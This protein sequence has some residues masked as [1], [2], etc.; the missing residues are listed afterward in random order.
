M[1]FDGAVNYA[2]RR[3]EGELSPKLTYHSFAHTKDEVVVA[4]ERLAKMEGVLGTDKALL[5]TAAYFHDLG[6]IY[7]RKEHE[8]KSA[9]IALDVLPGF[10]YTEIQVGIIEGIILA[11]RLPQCPKT[12]LE[13]IMA[14]GD[15]DGLGQGNFFDRGLDLRKELASFGI[16]S[17]D[18]DWYL[19][20][21]DLL[22]R[23]RYFTKSARRLRN[24]GKQDNLRKLRALIE[25]SKRLNEPN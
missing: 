23:H 14:D 11:T 13:Q 12:H 6:F 5:L 7:Q 17:S 18:Q 21:L 8:R 9:D 19:Q 20:E 24:R 3:L 16:I 4:V 2:L 22:M 25:E 15:L 10:R 1:D